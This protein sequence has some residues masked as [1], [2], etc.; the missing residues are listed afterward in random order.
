MKLILSL[1]FLVVTINLRVASA[2]VN[3][4]FLI[5][6][7]LDFTQDIIS[8]NL[9]S[10]TNRIDTYFGEKKVLEEKNGSSIKVEYATT[11]KE[12]S[13]QSSEPDFDI[14]VRFKQLENKLNFK[15]N[16][17]KKDED[18]TLENKQI[19]ENSS[20]NSAIEN[21]IF[22]ASIG[23]FKE[24]EKYWSISFDTG[25]KIES[26]LNPF[27]KARG[28]R[29]FYFG[30]TE[31]RLS[32][33]ILVEDIDGMFNSTDININRKLSRDFSFTYANKFV[34]KDTL[35]EL[36]TVHGPSIRQDI[37]DKQ[38]ISYNIRTRFKNKPKTY[39]ITGHEIFSA[40]RRDL[41]KQWIF[42]ELTPGLSFLSETD[43]ARTAFFT[44]KL[45]ALF[46]DF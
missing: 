18:E 16:S 6:Q 11:I 3:E 24:Q 32:N 15:F 45:Q 41:Y 37:D 43:Y 8:K 13:A 4:S 38:S 5:D 19:V 44:A 23:F 26:S 27:A 2:Q 7:N 14:K 9:F 25:I 21:S 28:R 29:S 36:T 31:L 10:V 22:R 1:L 30:E 34:W 46:G 20:E 35:N 39:A 33:K 12:K 17:S 42:L 40:Y